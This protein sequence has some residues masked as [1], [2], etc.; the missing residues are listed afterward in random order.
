MDMTAQ[1]QVTEDVTPQDN[2]QPKTTQPHGSE[3]KPGLWKLLVAAGGIL[4][5]VFVAMELVED[6]YVSPS[7]STLSVPAEHSHG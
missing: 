4:V 3:I 5:V 2:P 1:I 6:T 7:E